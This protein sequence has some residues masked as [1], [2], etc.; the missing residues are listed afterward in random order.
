ML[1]LDC[2]YDT[3]ALNSHSKQNLIALRETIRF[4][5]QL[6]LFPSNAK[7]IQGNVSIA[8]HCIHP[9]HAYTLREGK[10]LLGKFTASLVDKNNSAHS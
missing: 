4:A 7:V 9:W 6:T 5:V 10:L 3:S 8:V 1:I 2:L